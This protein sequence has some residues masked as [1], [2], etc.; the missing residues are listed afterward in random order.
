MVAMLLWAGR[1]HAAD[2][3]KK[4]K[5]NAESAIARLWQDPGDISR[6]DLYWGIGSEGGLPK[7][8]F[9]FV[10]EDLDGFN[11]KIDVKDAAG[12]I[13]SVKF[14]SQEGEVYSETAAVR[15]FWAL[16][17]MVGEMYFVPT[18]KI[19]G[20]K[21]LER[22]KSAL[23]A[24][25]TFHGARFK[26]YPH[27]STKTKI[28]WSWDKNPF[29]GT[30]ELSGLKVLT[31]LLANWNNGKDNNAVLELPTPEGKIEHWY[32]AS[33]LGATFGKMGSWSGK[34]T[35]WN[36]QDYRQQP[37]VESVTQDTLTLY[38]QGNQDIS[39]IPLEHAR[40]FAG[41]LSQLSDAQLKRAFEA[42]GGSPPEITGFA[43]ALKEKIQEL[44]KAV[45][46]RTA[47]LRLAQ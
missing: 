23:S 9:T 36:K 41:L 39:S 26:R 12:T 44:R 10:E 1:V 19:E 7:P 31:A 15:I 17:Y 2:E 16:G 40:W 46:V 29:V 28:V 25:G 22:A 11:P 6:K 5:E 43:A 14:Q 3:P 33:D 42:A 45:E 47:E 35:K 38:F 21:G 30:R 27:G 13:W 8:P 34:R 18:G 32:I 37:V 24:D 4:E 20:A